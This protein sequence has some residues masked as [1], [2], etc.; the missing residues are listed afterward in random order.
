LTDL[1][2]NARF[3]NHGKNLDFNFSK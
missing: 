1:Q 3:M 2:S